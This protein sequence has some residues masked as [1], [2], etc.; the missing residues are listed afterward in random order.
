[1]KTYTLV[2]AV[3]LC[4]LINSVADAE[5]MVFPKPLTPASLTLITKTNR[6]HHR[7]RYT[8]LKN[9]KWLEKSKYHYKLLE[10]GNSVDDNTMK[11]RV[12]QTGYLIL[13][14][15]FKKDA[16]NKNVDKKLSTPE[17]LKK[18]GWYAIGSTILKRQI[19]KD[20][21]VILKEDVEYH[22]FIKNVKKGE[23]YALISNTKYPPFVII[24]DKNIIPAIFKSNRLK[25]SS[26][27]LDL[28]V[29]R[30]ARK[31][32]QSVSYPDGIMALSCEEPDR[33]LMKGYGGSLT[34]ELIRQAWIIAARDEL[35]LA[36]RDDSLL[37]V[38]RR[39]KDLGDNPE[40]HILTYFKSNKQTDTLRT[41]VYQMNKNGGIVVPFQN[42]HEFPDPNKSKLAIKK[43]MVSTRL[44]KIIQHAERLS[45]GEFRRAIKRRHP[46]TTKKIELKPFRNDGVVP[47]EIEKQLDQWDWLSQYSALRSL[48]KEIEAEGL[49]L[50]N[51]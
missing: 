18:R 41:V 43:K 17:S 6:I 40:F 11:F 21:K 33:S 39:Q 36:T 2:A 4:F 47:E 38:D 29:K 13:G 49:N 32:T 27:E 42:T 50:H 44:W 7:L 31:A 19:W 45:R 46:K 22:V 24:P 37:E 30:N 16:G 3:C 15:D 48:H 23:K 5:K 35:G 34:R 8:R 1:M 26:D 14:F 25:V 10:A 9:D 20:D 28:I 12:D 51:C